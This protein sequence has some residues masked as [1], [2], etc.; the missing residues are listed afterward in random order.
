M[1]QRRTDS[2]VYIA[3]A[4]A[5]LT[6]ITSIVHPAAPAG[7]AR[8]LLLTSAPEAAAAAGAIGEDPNAVTP[9]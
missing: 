8:F 6:A 4:L 2:H 7:L 3:L 1:I 5:T 9:Q